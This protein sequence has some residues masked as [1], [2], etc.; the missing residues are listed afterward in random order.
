MGS[1][2]CFEMLSDIPDNS[3]SVVLADPPWQYRDVWVDYPTM[4]L[5]EVCDLSVAR[6]CKPDAL[7]FLW[8]TFPMMAEALQVVEAWGFQYKT[9]AFLWVKLDSAGNPSWGEG[10]YTRSNTEPCLVATRGDGRSCLKQRDRIA[11]H[12]VVQARRHGHSRKPEEVRRR[13]EELTCG[14]YLELFARRPRQGWICLGNELEPLQYRLM[15]DA[16]G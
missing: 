12:Q 9:A 11:T 15:D 3:F 16:E 13:I 4:S 5:E 2:R 1:R 8:A 7:L 6:V 10:N 14:P